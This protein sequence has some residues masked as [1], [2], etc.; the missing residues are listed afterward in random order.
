MPEQTINIICNVVVALGTTA[1]A[2]TGILQFLHSTQQ[3]QHRPVESA[4]SRWRALQFV[5]GVAS[6]AFFTTLVTQYLYPPYGRWGTPGYKQFLTES[7]L[8]LLWC[9][10]IIALIWY[11]RVPHT[12][13]EWWSRANIR[14]R[15]AQGLII[16]AAI[17]IAALI[18]TF[19]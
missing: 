8:R 19:G 17:I 14:S 18:L 3:H 2:V 13:L 7:H 15:V 9:L 6:I 10:A 4:S 1:M 12:L 16:G 5:V 11:L